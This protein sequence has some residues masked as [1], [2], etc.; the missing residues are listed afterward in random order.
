MKVWTSIA[1]ALKAHGACA[2]ITQL[3]IQGSAPREAGA[4][5]VLMP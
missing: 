4:R 3:E 2:L 5:M 1:A